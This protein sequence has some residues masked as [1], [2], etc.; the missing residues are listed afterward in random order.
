MKL[1]FLNKALTGL[2]LSLSCLVNS[3]N[4]G[5]I[6]GTNFE[7]QPESINY[8]QFE[9]SGLSEINWQLTGL[10]DGSDKY[11]DIGYHFA[12]FEGS[13]GS[14][15]DMLFHDQTDVLTKGITGTFGPGI[16][17]FAVGVHF[18][19]EIEARTGFASTPYNTT[20][21]FNFRLFSDALVVPVPAP[22]SL[23]VFALALIGFSARHFKK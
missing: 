18:M 17:T 6:T 14:F 13:F 10:P 15:G 11:S 3:A 21:F 9:L 20:Q 7:I 1:K 12:L 16:Y 19:T 4:A 5:L 8:I 2:I 23:A 22:F